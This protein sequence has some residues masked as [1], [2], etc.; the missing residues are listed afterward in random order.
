[1]RGLWQNERQICLD[2]W[3]HSVKKLWRNVNTV[4][5]LQ[6]SNCETN[7]IS[8]LI[9]KGS[10]LTD[11]DS[12]CNGINNYFLTIGEKLDEEHSQKTSNFNYHDFKS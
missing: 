5:S 10:T 8:K 7:N 1:M 12:I 11:D 9:I 3:T 4:C 2:F 6:K